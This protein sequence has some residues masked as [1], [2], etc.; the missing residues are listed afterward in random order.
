MKSFNENIELVG[1][2]IDA[3]GVLVIVT[4]VLIAT[5]QFLAR[6]EWSAYQAYRHSLARA[7]LLGLELLVAG[8]I[9]R[10]VGVSPTRESVMVLAMIVLIRTFL[11][12]SMTLE[13]EGRWPWQKARS[14]EEPRP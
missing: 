11:S 8:D 3:F 9:I 2:A 7:I 4:G 10:T 5:F 1:M 6:R 12:T 14:E 13:I